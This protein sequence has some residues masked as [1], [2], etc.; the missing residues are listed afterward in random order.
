MDF[1]AYADFIF[2][3]SSFRFVQFIWTFDTYRN[4]YSV[5]FTA[6]YFVSVFFWLC[7][8]CLSSVGI[9]WPR[10]LFVLFAAL[11]WSSFSAA[12]WILR[13]SIGN[14]SA[15]A[16][17]AQSCCAVLIYL[18]STWVVGRLGHFFFLIGL[19]PLPLVCAVAM[20]KSSSINRIWWCLCVFS[21]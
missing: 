14:Q 15:W 21:V 18:S 19:V 17:F 11:S 8:L 13:R 5:I 12:F 16:S 4:D 1:I 6:R 9:Q 2:P 7:D 3:L 10:S 20:S